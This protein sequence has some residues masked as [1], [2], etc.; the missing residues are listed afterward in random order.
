MTDTKLE[1]SINLGK[2]GLEMFFPHYGGKM[3]VYMWDTPEI[4]MDNGLSSG[5][6]WQYLIDIGVRNPTTGRPISRASVIFFLNR[7]VNLGIL[8]YAEATG[9]GG[10]HRLYAPVGTEVE[11]WAWVREIANRRLDDEAPKE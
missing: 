8:G 7:C 5:R 3:L 9:K 10:V 6:A 4:N 11:F 2:T 1:L